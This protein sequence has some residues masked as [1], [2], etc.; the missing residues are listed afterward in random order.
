[1]T[2]DNTSRDTA[3]R[4]DLPFVGLATF[5]RQPACPD[6]DKLNGADVARIPFDTAS[7]YRVGTRF[8]PSTTA[9]AVVPLF[10]VAGSTV[11]ANGAE[12]A[13]LSGRRRE[14]STG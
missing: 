4:M 13:G 5:A 7:S 14:P 12:L 3:D 11:A 8:G 9:R 6:W 1:M 2:T 10:G